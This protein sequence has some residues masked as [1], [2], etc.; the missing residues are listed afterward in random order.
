MRLIRSRTPQG[1]VWGALEGQSYAVLEGSFET[2]FRRTG[3]QRPFSADALMAPVTP[4]KIVAVATNYAA[5]AAE[6]GR[7]VPDEPRIFLKPPT[8]VSAPGEPIEI[9]PGTVRVDPE[10][11]LGVVIGR[12]LKRATPSETLGA[13]FGY[14]IVNDVT[15]RDFQKKDGVFGRGKGFDSFCPTGPW[16]ETSLD[17][18]DIEVRVAVDGETRALGR[19]SDMHFDVPTLL[20]FISNIMTLLPG[21]L[22][23]TGT[24]PGVAPIVAGNRVAITIE[25]IGTLE[26]PVRDRADR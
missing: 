25:G 12:V 16:V 21:D 6:M 11:E 2:G 8:A 17:P 15:C 10:G 5:H 3:Q 4:S 1:P 13:V 14:T 23:A 7:T 9:P 19:T 26:N 22:I 24:P 20:A 18:R